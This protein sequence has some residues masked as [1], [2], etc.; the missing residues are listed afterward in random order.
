MTLT[1]SGP[2]RTLISCTTEWGT[3]ILIHPT[4]PCLAAMNEE[5]SF[6][7]LASPEKKGVSLPSNTQSSN[8]PFLKDEVGG[9]KHWDS[10]DT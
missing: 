10:T 6:L 9:Q 2:L 1:A 8:E 4:A 3:D 5:T 7:A